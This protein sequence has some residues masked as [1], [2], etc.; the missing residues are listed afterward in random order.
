MTTS[1]VDQTI[2]SASSFTSSIA[3]NAHVGYAWGSYNNLA[4]VETD[5]RYLGVTTLRDSLAGDPSAQ[6]VLDGLAAAGFKFDFLVP[7]GLPATGSAG[8]QQYIAS[9]Q[10]FETAHPNSIVA[11]E[12]LNEANIQPFSYNGSS[13]MAAA[14]QF[15]QVYYAAIKGDAALAGIPVYDLTLGY[16]DLSGYSSLGNLSASTDFASSHAYVPTESTPQAAIAAAI[17]AASS[18][19]AGA[20]SVI[21]E[22][23]YTTQANTQYLGVDQTVQ[24]KSILNTLVDAYK[25]GVGTTYL[26]ELLDGNSSSTN[27]EDHFGLFNSDGTPK[28]AATAIHNLTTI[29]NDNGNGGHTPTAPLGYSLSGLPDSG[30]SMVLGK[31]NGAYDLVVWAEPQ[32][33]NDATSTEIA[34]STQPVT[35]N[36][37]SVHQ[38]VNVY[39]PLNGTTP[40]ATY[41]NV[42]QIVV[43]VSDHPLVIEIDA[44][45]TTPTTATG[46]V[47]ASGTATDIVSQLW[48]LNA[49][50]N[51]ATITL[52]DTHTLPVASQSTMNYI[53]S[54]YGKAL[55]AIQGGYTFS[56][57]TSSPQWSQ[58]LTYDASGKL[59]STS[60]SAMSNGVVTSTYVVNADGSTDATGYTAGVKTNETHVNA[61]GSKEIYAFNIQ[62]QAFTTEHDSYNASGLLTSVVQTHSDGSLAFKIVQASDGTKTADAYDATGNLISEAVQGTNGSS[63][64]TVYA[65]GVKAA[66]YIVNADQTRDNW[67]YNI[68]GQTYTTQDQHLDT[69][70]KVV[71][72]TRTHADGSLDSTETIG[73]DGT[74][75]I[76]NYDATGTETMSTVFHPD[77]SRDVYL[78]NITGQ[79]YTTEHDTYDATGLLTSQVRGNSGGTSASSQLVETS[80]GTKIASTYDASGNLTSQAVQ[81]TD[82]SYSTTIYTAGVK[83]A[84]YILNADHTQDNWT[85]N[86]TGQSYTT[87]DQHLD[88]TGKVVAVTRMHADGSLDSSEIIGSDGTTTINNYDATGTETM[89]TIFHPDGSRDVSLLNV[90]GQ[91]YTTEHDSYNA[92]GSLTSVVQT[93]SDGSLAFKMVQASDGTKTS[94]SYDTTGNLTSEVVQGTNG[95]YSTTV[96]SAGVKTAAYIVNPDH[97]QDNWSYNVTGQSYTT[98][99]QHLDTTGKVVA[100]TRMHADGSLDSS[101]I[102]GS[103]GTTTINNYDATGTETVSTIFHPDGSKD[104]SLFNITGQAYTS[105]HDTYDATGLLTT[106]LQSHSDGSLAFKMVETSDGTK[107]SDFYD[108]TGNL[109]S[110]VVQGTNG[111][112]STTVYSA[113]VK[114]AAYI[115]NPDHTQDNW[116]YNVSG[117]SY[118]TQDQ[119]LDATG[120]VV[121]VTR[122]HADGSL[123]F[124]QVIASDGTN[125]SNNYDASGNETMSTIVHPNG[126]MDIYKFQVA[127]SPGATE[128]DSYAANGGLLAIDVLNANG[129]THNITAVASGQTIV[130]DHGNEQISNFVAG[131]A[132]NHD[133]IQIALSLAADYSHLQVAQSGA[134]TLVHISATDTVTLKNV[135]AA[136]LDHSNF[137]FA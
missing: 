111:S 38:S 62:G 96:Y 77:G 44:P 20:P 24:A 65:A 9:L 6:P 95:S 115:V 58:T 105:E 42:S 88:T 13:S 2:L 128:H 123:D 121:G 94:D 22:T 93:H 67:S 37:G 4:L 110:E 134:D 1:T 104:V 19:A 11:L 12:G 78:L 107:T 47:N 133:T 117:Q 91:A 97:T 21:T 31:S 118:T 83:T 137:L 23:G 14:A 90:K 36:L 79:A 48:T 55:A 54:N 43:P 70:G 132:T 86:V 32:I 108:A 63:S 68:T 28:L 16:N 113:G 99:D 33:W 29:L 60:D 127:G 85:Y 35:V 129:L 61:D 119:H 72:V 3:V 71:A 124:T 8:L 75:T 82:G 136:S 51:L 98:Q 41:S 53:I 10:Q 26:Y 64:T 135:S 50:P 73:S 74:T 66:A 120:T 114:T 40:I 101:E 126:S 122:T 18:V 100:V 27:S 92:A 81:K 5:L 69:T 52:T 84:A 109:T 34:A 103:D 25:A 102:V 112:Y 59:L 15:Q 57:T 49:D 46:P 125:T 56:V 106:E 30:N 80:D 7:S 39:D 45:A 87:Q 116:S 17:S 76:N 130:F 131:T 89:S